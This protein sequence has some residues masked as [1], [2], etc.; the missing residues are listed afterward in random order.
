LQ[1]TGL[2][3]TYIAFGSKKASWR[4]YQID[5]RR[6]DLNQAWQPQSVPKNI[7]VPFRINPPTAQ[8]KR[9]IAPLRYMGVVNDITDSLQ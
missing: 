7:N 9:A 3:D 6:V 5:L 4:V 2:W 8:V 1:K